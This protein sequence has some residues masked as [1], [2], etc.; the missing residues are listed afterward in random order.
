MSSKNTLAGKTIVV[1]RP[2][3]QAQN[4]LGILEARLA[5]VVHF[6]VISICA[7]DNIKSA[8]QSFNKLTDYQVIIFISANAV[9]YTMSIAQE[10]GVNFEHSTLAAVGPATKTAL[11]NYG[12]NVAIVPSAGFTSEALLNDPALLNIAE[13]NIMIVRGRGGREHLRETLEARNARVTYAEV[14]QRQLPTERNDIN[15]GELPQQNTAILLYSVESAQNLW[16]LCTH[17]EQQWLQNLT[18]ITGSSRIA[19]ATIQVGFAKNPIIAE[20]PSDGAILTAL[21][22]WLED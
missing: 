2:L 9:H 21:D 14:Y 3:A 17:E 12:C 20:N 4:I 1:T 18:F 13:Q 6:P 15:L 8:K 5:K 7:A 16:S 11:E 22:A 10:L 19:E